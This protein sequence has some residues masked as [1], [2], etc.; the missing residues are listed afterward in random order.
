MEYRVA[1]P[2]AEHPARPRP[3]SVSS[4]HELARGIVQLA[5]GIVHLTQRMSVLPGRVVVGYG[6]WTR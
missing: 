2:E 5:R 4:V 1:H 3:C 6:G